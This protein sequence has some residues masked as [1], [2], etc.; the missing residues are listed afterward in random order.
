MMANKLS[1]NA[2]HLVANKAIWI[3]S[4]N[5][6]LGDYKV[7]KTNTGKDGGSIEIDRPYEGVDPK[8]SQVAEK[9]YGS[10]EL[11]GCRVYWR[12]E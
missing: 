8:I 12:I 11:Y 9:T 5:L 6:G 4:I 3:A 10:I 7:L 1:A 2:H